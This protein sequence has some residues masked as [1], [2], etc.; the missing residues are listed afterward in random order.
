MP[1]ILIIV[2]VIAALGL[3]GFMWTN[4]K[5]EES[6]VTAATVTT[7]AATTPETS[8]PTATV[9][10]EQ[11]NTESVETVY[12]DGVYTASV[13]YK[14]PD[15]AEHPVTVALTLEGDTVTA[16]SVSF[17]GEATGASA[18]FQKKFT[19]AYTAQ[20]VG[21]SLDSIKL[22]RVGGA[23]L[24]TGAWNAAQAEIVAQAKS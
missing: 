12:K 23:S 3:G 20:V 24:T 14:S 19:A 16:G 1:F 21:K 9:T 4:H 6:V 18:D 5:D 17:G 11:T 8:E 15:R 13:S 7:P 2:G 22:S 10:T